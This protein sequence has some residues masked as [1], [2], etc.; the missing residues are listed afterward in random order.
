MHM[1]RLVLAPAISVALVACEPI[2]DPAS[3][4][5]RPSFGAGSPV[6]ESVTGSGHHNAAIRD[7]EGWS[8]FSFNARKTA[9]GVAGRFQATNHGLSWL[10]GAISCFT[11]V[12][13][14]A[15]LG[16]NVEIASRPGL[17]GDRVFRVVD[18][19]EGSNA[20]PD[21]KSR[22][23]SPGPYG[24]AQNFCDQTPDWPPSG[25]FDMEAG[26]IQVRLGPTDTGGAMVL[27]PGE[28][29]PDGFCFFGPW[30]A[31]DMSAVRTPNGR[32]TLSCSFSGLPPIPKAETLK[33]WT[34]F[35]DF[36]GLSF[37]DQT[38]WVRTPSGNAS[39]TCRFDE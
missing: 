35:L 21:Q 8:T 22:L 38:A 3:V 12:G 16:V 25:L 28:G 1:T 10:K 14:E 17:L 7:W 11:V 29:K 13:N 2:S 9:D 5:V 32:A 36:G 31:D 23:A 37:T 27:N 30:T 24:S 33:G 18:N 20:E 39:V 4:V 26:N 19:G 6:V 15:W 34:C